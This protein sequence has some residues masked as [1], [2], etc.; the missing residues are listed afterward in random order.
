MKFKKACILAASLVVAGTAIATSGCS[1]KSNGGKLVVFCQL[2]RCVQT[3]SILL[4]KKI[5][6][7]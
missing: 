7:K 2:N 6:L 4:L 5:K 3:F 1:S